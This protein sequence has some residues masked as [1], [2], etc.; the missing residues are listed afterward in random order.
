VGE[1]RSA[2]AP[3]IAMMGDEPICESAFCWRQ[4]E[5]QKYLKVE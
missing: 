2:G 1:G 4:L 5:P 3:S